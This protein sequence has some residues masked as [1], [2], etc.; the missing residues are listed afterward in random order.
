M[1]RGT[2][3]VNTWSSTK[4]PGHKINVTVARPGEVVYCNPFFILAA[5]AWRPVDWSHPGCTG[6]IGTKYLDGAGAAEAQGGKVNAA[7]RIVARQHWITCVTYR[8]GG[9]GSA[10]SKCGSAIKG[11]CESSKF[12][13]AACS[14]C[15]LYTSPSP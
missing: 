5:S 2:E 1:V 7:G 9:Q 12:I 11:S 3:K 10:I 14:G 6:I 4:T 8:I 13:T 15:L